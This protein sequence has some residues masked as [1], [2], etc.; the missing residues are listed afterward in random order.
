MTVVFIT[1]KSIGFVFS[2][3]DKF[4]ARGNTSWTEVDPWRRILEN[5]E[6]NTFGVDIPCV[7]ELGVTFVYQWN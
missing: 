5:L 7:N 3:I 2:K 4:D 6:V 1:G